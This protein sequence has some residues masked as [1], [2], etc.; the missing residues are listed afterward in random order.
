MLG[1]FACLGRM[2]LGPNRVLSKISLEFQ[3]PMFLDID[4][5]VRVV[6]KSFRTTSVRLC[7][8]S[9][10][11]TKADFTFIAGHSVEPPW[12]ESRATVRR[13]PADPDDEELIDGTVVEGEYLPRQAAVSEL[14]NRFEIDERKIGR[15][16]L[17]ALLWSSYLVGMEQPGRRGLFYKLVLAFEN[18]EQCR[19]TCLTYQA[20]IVSLN[21]LNILHSQL[22]LFSREEMVGKAESWAFVIPKNRLATAG[23]LAELLPPSDHLKGRVALVIGASRGLGAMLTMALASQGC[24][25]LANFNRSEAEAHYLVDHLE[26]ATGTVKLMKGDA[27]DLACCEEIEVR[28]SRECGRLDFLICNACPPIPSLQLEPKMVTR[29][30]SYF[31]HALALVSVPMSFFLRVLAKNFGRSVVIS[32]MSVETPPK[33]WPHYVAL[34]CAVEGLARVAAVQYPNANFLLVRPPRLQTDLINPLS[35]TFGERRAMPPEVAATRIVQR[36]QGAATS[37]VEVFSLQ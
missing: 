30:N 4:Y 22:R 12:G 1:V 21:A 29:I 13:M 23:T 5:Q 17:L 35:A 15:V 8:G 25:V 14:L 18:L 24:T 26:N 6:E 7:D 28:L 9:K 31:S 3:R 36:L 11:M 32:S 2:K 10:I 33:E 37:Q 27:S 19:E 20:R 34:K 16:Q